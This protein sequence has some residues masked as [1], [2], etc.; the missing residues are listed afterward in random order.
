MLDY[1]LYVRKYS[2]L[3]NDY[4]F[5]VYSVSCR[6]I[7]AAVGYF[8]LNCFERIERLDYTLSTPERLEFWSSQNVT[9]FP[10][11]LPPDF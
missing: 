9:I 6:N 4:R 3:S 2:I 5:Y 11:R 8:Y 10:Y 7:Y 1:L